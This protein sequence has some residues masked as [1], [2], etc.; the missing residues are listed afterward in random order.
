MTG[1]WVLL[2]GIGLGLRH[3][4]DTDHVI[5]VSALVQREPGVWRAARI[6]A[7]WGAGHTVAFLTLGL[8]IVLAEV[9]LPPTFERA[10][11]LLVASMLIGLGLWHLARSRHAAVDAGPPAAGAAARPVAIGLVHGLAGSAGVALLA[12]STIASRALAVAYL[13]LVA[14]GT[15][16]GM[17]GLT[18]ILSRPISW[19]MRRAGRLRQGVTVFAAILSLALGLS[20]LGR[21]LTSEDLVRDL[22]RLDAPSSFAA[23]AQR[24][25]APR[26]LVAPRAPPPARATLGS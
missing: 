22:R 19:T 3:A 8:L 13:G 6:A 10:A 1:L 25:P 7:L 26:G 15:V 21:V 17:V 24:L 4:I 18:V 20:V 2:L 12:A 9:R 14:L 23:Y 5:V 16:I 11:D